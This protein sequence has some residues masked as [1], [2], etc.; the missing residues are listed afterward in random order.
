MK[1]GSNTPWHLFRTGVAYLRQGLSPRRGPHPAPV[2]AHPPRKAQGGW[3]RYPT[4]ADVDR[5]TVLGF[6]LQMSRL[7]SAG[8]SLPSACSKWGDSY[9]PW[10]WQDIG[11]RFRERQDFLRDSCA[12]GMPG[13]IFWEQLWEASPLTTWSSDSS[14]SRDPVLKDVFI[15]DL[16]LSRQEDA[17]TI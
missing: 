10:S 11:K 2:P 12:L 17:Q 13:K 9:S 15:S 8:I 7:W 14:F 16:F 4:S 3:L 6:T 1:K 5:T